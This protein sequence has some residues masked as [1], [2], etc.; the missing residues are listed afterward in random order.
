MRFLMALLSL[1]VPF[2]SL[3]IP[4]ASTNVKLALNWKPEPQ[5]GGFYA[6]T[7]AKDDVKQG[8]KIEIL[9]GGSGTP[10]VQM[11]ANGK[12]DFAIV[13]A[14]E[15]AI[16]N[17]RNPKNKVVALFAVFQTNPQMIMC[18]ADRGFK[19]L[20]DVYMSEGVLAIQSGL[21]YAQFLK[22]HYPDSKVKIVPYLG[23]ITNYIADS[24]YCQQGFTTSEPLSAEKAGKPA[25]VFLVADEGFNPYTTVVAMRASTLDS[26]PDLAKKMVMAV[27]AGWA[28]YL[29]NP[30]IANEH[31]GKLNKAM[32]ADTFKKSAAAQASLIETP[33]SKKNGLGAMT[34][35]R[36]TLL[37]SQLKNLKVIREIQETASLFQNF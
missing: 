30:K 8:L 22:G 25:K 1:L 3:A 37:V 10:T 18:H 21:T 11:L 6:A 34:A 14:E 29:K 4:V 26:R 12:V 16:N 7:I 33:E 31:M 28:S 9:E 35:E 17:D 13:S 2:V 20:K 24:N 32:D 27:K 23:G 15:I 36:W 5:F 19:T